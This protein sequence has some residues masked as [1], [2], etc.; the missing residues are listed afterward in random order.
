MDLRDVTMGKFFVRPLRWWGRICP[1]SW[2]R[3]KVYENL[4]ATLVAPVAPAVTFLDLEAM[5][6]SSSASGFPQF[7]A[8]ACK[9]LKFEELLKT[10][11]VSVT[12]YNF[13]MDKNQRSIW[14]QAS[15]K[16]FSIFIQ[17]AFNL[18]KFPCENFGRAEDMEI[19]HQQKWIEVFEKIQ[20]TAT[21]PEIIKFCHL[22]RETENPRKSSRPLS[23][24]H[25]MS[26]IFKEQ[27]GH[28][29]KQIRKLCVTPKMLSHYS[30]N[31]INLHFLEIF[32]SPQKTENRIHRQHRLMQ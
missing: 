10:R 20:E 21:I 31:S 32:L 18:E 23:K 27:D 4:G 1:P 26:C 19:N 9:N 17:D 5:I 16:V 25:E 7:M 28:L 2:K 15:N 22:L 30:S 13:L 8:E 12:F 3:V 11:L 24:I 14:I 29:P 6:T